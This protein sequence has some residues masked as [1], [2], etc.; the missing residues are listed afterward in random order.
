MRNIGV[1]AFAFFV[2]LIGFSSA[3]SAQSGQVAL[4]RATVEPAVDYT[5]G[6]TLFLLTPDKAPFPSNANPHAVAPLYLVTYPATSTLSPSLLNCQPT[7]CDHV[8]V[9]PFPAPGYPNGGAAC[10]QYGLPANGCAL[11]LGHDHLVGI[12]RTGGDFN[13]AWHV[14]LVVFTPQGISHGLANTRALTLN[15]VSAMVTNGDAFMVDT[16]ITFNCSAVSAAVYQRGT[17]LSF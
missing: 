13:V 10:T 8:N 9:L 2:G 6:A 4:G 11:L 17:P 5:N 7:N 12:A 14:T 1:L 16:P 3:A 15:Q